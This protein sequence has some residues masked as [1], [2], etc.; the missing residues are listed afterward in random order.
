MTRME[1]VQTRNRDAKLVCIELQPNAHTQAQERRDILNVGGFSD[2]VFGL[3]SD[4]AA[5]NMDDGH[6]I[7]V[8]KAVEISRAGSAETFLP[9]LR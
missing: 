2:Q 7:G 5:G 8:I 4:F 6:W 1:R 9:R 3:V